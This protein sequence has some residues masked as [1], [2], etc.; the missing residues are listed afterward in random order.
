[1]TERPFAYGKAFANMKTNFIFHDEIAK[2]LFKLIRLKGV[3]NVGGKSQSIFNFAKTFN[4]KVKKIFV[5][6]NQ[7]KIFPL[8]STMN[9]SKFKKILK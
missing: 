6:K 7:L 4:P 5:K 2:N 3:L 1:M 8:N 9:I